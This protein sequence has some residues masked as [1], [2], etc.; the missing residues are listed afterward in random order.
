MIDVRC[1]ACGQMTSIHSE[2]VSMGV[3]VI[4]RECGAILAVAKVR[5]LVL[6]E[7]DPE[8]DE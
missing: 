3:E 2:S 7:T 8:D 6:T 4:C 1:P 5:P